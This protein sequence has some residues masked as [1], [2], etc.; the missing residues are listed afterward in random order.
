MDGGERGGV[1]A[2]AELG[3][4]AGGVVCGVDD[5]DG[6]PLGDPL[7]RLAGDEGHVLVEP[8]ALV[9]AV[10]REVPAAELVVGGVLQLSQEGEGSFAEVAELVERDGAELVAGGRARRLTGARARP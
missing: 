3:H 9:V 10:G 7:A 6:D 1:G 4:G 2:G 5:G 8:M